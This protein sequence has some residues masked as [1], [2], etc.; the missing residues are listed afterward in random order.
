MKL[1]IDLET[2]GTTQKAHV[3]SIG[4]AFF[5]DSN[6]VS[7][8]HMLLP[9]QGQENRERSYSTVMWW[10]AQAVKNPDAAQALLVSREEGYSVGSALATLRDDITQ[11]KPTE[12][13]ANSPTFDC[14]IL[15]DLY[16]Q[17]NMPTP[18][19][20]WQERDFRT[21]KA[22]ADSPSPAFE[23]VQHNAEADAIY[24]AKCVH[25]WLSGLRHVQKHFRETTPGAQEV[26]H[27]T[28]E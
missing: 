13:W 6:L 20:F 23:G 22:M 11:Y 8:R 26:R 5:E 4:L 2:L 15:R 18:W 1:M 17:N 21:L 3:L 10:V 9:P 25:H 14:A 24:Q 12:V 19:Q 16:D 28:A 27:G 7:S